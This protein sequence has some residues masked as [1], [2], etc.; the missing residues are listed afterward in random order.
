MTNTAATSDWSPAHHPEAIA[1]SEANRWF[2][3]I[4]LQLLRL[5]DDPDRRL[6]ADSHQLDARLLVLALMALTNAAMLMRQASKRAANTRVSAGMTKARKRFCKALP[7]IEDIRN[8]LTHYDYWALGMGG[9]PQGVRREKGHDPSD[10]AR[11]FWYFGF[12]RRA[13]TVT[14][15]PYSFG[16]DEAERA[17]RDLYRKICQ[18]GQALDAQTSP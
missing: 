9:G 2:L 13:G 17:A 18:A 15:G 6:P 11:D 3:I 8:G 7:G 12:D 1:V 14:F 4:K 16:I 5:R 10:I